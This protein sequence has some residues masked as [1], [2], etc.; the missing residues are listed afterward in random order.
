MKKSRKIKDVQEEEEDE[1]EVVFDEGEGKD[2]VNN[3]HAK[4]LLLRIGILLL[5]CRR[6]R[7]TCLV[8]EGTQL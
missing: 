2:K 4:K 3:F 7:G 6:N 8:L 5:Q 1:D